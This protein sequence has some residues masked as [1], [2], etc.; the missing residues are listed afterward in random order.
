MADTWTEEDLEEL[1]K[2]VIQGDDPC[3]AKRVIELIESYE[4]LLN[5]K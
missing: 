4:E 2:E 1:R 3:L 5:K